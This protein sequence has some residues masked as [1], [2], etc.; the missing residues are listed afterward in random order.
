MV[1]CS[2]DR[3]VVW[4]VAKAACLV[5][6]DLLLLLQFISALPAF[7]SKQSLLLL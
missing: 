5:R 2:I 3:L 4:F 1:V 7:A 6:L